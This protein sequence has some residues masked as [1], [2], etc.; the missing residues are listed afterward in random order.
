MLNKNDEYIKEM[1]EVVFSDDIKE[2]IMSNIIK[3]KKKNR[4]IYVSA[5]ALLTFF[6]CIIAIININVPDEKKSEFLYEE[7]IEKLGN[8]NSVKDVE[9]DI[10]NNIDN[11]EINPSQMVILNIQSIQDDMDSFGLNGHFTGDDREYSFGYII[12]KSYTEV[13]SGCTEEFISNQVDIKDGTQCSIYIINCSD[14]VLTFSGEI[15]VNANDLVYRDY[16]KEALQVEGKC[17]III[18]LNG[19]SSYDIEG[20]YLYNCITQETIR[21][22]FS[23]MIEYESEQDGVYL[24]YA[25]TMD[26]ERIELSKNVTVEYSINEDDC[27]MGLSTSVRAVGLFPVFPVARRLE[28][29]GKA[30]LR[31]C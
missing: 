28:P 15:F 20:I 13:L 27:I 21:R 19:L 18:D 10:N 3:Q 4:K 2:R 22:E 1:N 16:G 9:V 6:L 31:R 25:M 29:D 24:I 14:N 26:G 8:V 5:T 17:K 7:D 23:N 12:D 30:G 11:L